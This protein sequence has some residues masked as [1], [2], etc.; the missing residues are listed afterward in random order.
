MRM[1][2]SL[3]STNND[4]LRK[5]TLAIIEE[6]VREANVTFAERRRKQGRHNRKLGR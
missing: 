4:S 6:T 5:L 2:V 1:L 3:S